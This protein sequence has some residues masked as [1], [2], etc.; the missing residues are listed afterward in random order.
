MAVGGSR[1]WE[2]TAANG[3]GRWRPTVMGGSSGYDGQWRLATSNVGDGKRWWL[4]MANNGGW[5]GRQWRK[6]TDSG[7]RCVRQW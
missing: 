4:T 5:G 6:A 7:G 1:Q 2:T 3:E